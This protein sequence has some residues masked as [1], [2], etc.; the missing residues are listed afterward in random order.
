ME[1]NFIKQIVSST[2]LFHNNLSFDNVGIIFRSSSTLKM[3]AKTGLSGETIGPLLHHLL[4]G[5]FCCVG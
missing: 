4:E 2:Y 3:F 5:M 1:V